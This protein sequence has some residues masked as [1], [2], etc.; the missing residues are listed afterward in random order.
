MKIASI[1]IPAGYK[2][3]SAIRMAGLKDVVVL[4]GRNGSG[5][6]RILQALKSYAGAK[7]GAASIFDLRQQME[8][9][10]NNIAHFEGLIEV[11]RSKGSLDER[12]QGELQSLER[13]LDQQ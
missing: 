10:A 5:K 1:N 13:Q 7:L 6:T 8:G 3:L 11:L 2:G 9:N 4:A 12:Q